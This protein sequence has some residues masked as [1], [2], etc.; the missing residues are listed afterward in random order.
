MKA[1]GAACVTSD[2]DV[3]FANKTIKLCIFKNY[4]SVTPLLFRLVSCD[5]YV[6]QCNTQE[7]Q[8]TKTTNQ[9]G[10][11]CVCHPPL[12]LFT[13]SMPLFRDTLHSRIFHLSPFPTSHC[14]PN[15]S[16]V[17][18]KQGVTAFFLNQHGQR[19]QALHCNLL[20]SNMIF[21]DAEF[22]K[23]MSSHYEAKL[24]NT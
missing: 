1:T 3:L 5:S 13:S 16:I 10:F 23:S 21:T 18:K 6:S 9:R 20:R 15:F 24:I 19:F 4:L 22:K 2:H 8:M 14:F 12:F 11:C 7:W 17:N